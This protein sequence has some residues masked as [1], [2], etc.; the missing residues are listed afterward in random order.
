MTKAEAILIR[1]RQLMG[2]P[3]TA[4]DLQE[5]IFTLQMKRNGRMALPKLPAAMRERLNA[6]LL[7]NLGMAI[8]RGAA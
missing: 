3:V 2:E 5:A 8:G 4:G 6:I 1:R 7:F